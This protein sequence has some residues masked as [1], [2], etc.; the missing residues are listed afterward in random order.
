MA[1]IRGAFVTVGQIAFYEQVKQLLLAT[2]Y[3]KD[4]ITTHFSSSFVAGCLHRKRFQ[5]NISRELF[6][7]FRCSSNSIDNALG[8]DENST[9]ERQTWRI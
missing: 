9:D 2:G 8:R 6:V 3:F 4:N 7:D 5:V 1:V